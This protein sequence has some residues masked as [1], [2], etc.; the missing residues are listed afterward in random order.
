MEKKPLEKKEKI[1]PEEKESAEVDSNRE[2]EGEEKAQSNGYY[3]RIS[4]R[5]RNIKYLM[6]LFMKH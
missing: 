6:L 3:L 4:K 1:M 2:V 5:L